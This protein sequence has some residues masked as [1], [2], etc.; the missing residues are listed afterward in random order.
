SITCGS[1]SQTVHASTQVVVSQQVATSITANVATA[2]LLSPVVLTWTA[3]Q[4]ATCNASGGDGQDGWGGPIPSSGTATVTG[5]QAG[6][7]SY[8]ISCNGLA[9]SA[10]VTY[11]PAGA[12]QPDVPLPSTSLS[13]DAMNA[14]LGHGVTLNWAAEN[15]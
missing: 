7:V 12:D 3:P 14:P 2:H 6:T 9:A 13:S 5:H 11:S 8:A 15:S 4:S 1:G 10:A